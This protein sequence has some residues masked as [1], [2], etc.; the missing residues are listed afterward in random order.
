MKRKR[1]SLS[2]EVE[3]KRTK[4]R[5]GER[6]VR[7]MQ[8]VIVEVVKDIEKKQKRSLVVRKKKA[9]R[10]KAIFVSKTPEI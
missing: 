9:I 2:D 8:K 10:R 3:K 6:F 7:T 4:K 1:G 5:K